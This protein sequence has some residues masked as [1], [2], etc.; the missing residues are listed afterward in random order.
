MS[1]MER[2]KRNN[3]IGKNALKT[4]I[5]SQQKERASIR[6]ADKLIIMGS[7]GDKQADQ[8]RWVLLEIADDKSH[9]LQAT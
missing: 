8:S 2:T 7:S 1:R 5:V 6:F 4:S 3:G 9:F